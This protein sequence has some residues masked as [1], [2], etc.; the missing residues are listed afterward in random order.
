MASLSRASKEVCI[1]VMSSCLDTISC[2]PSFT[3]PTNSIEVSS[4]VTRLLKAPIMVSIW[5]SRDFKLMVM[6]AKT[7]A[8][9]TIKPPAT[10]NM[11]MCCLR[12]SFIKSS[13]LCVAFFM[14]SPAPTAKLAERVASSAD[15]S[16]NILT[17]S[18]SSLSL[19]GAAAAACAA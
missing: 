15:S 9:T 4:S 19:T 10:A 13:R 17:P 7:A 16:A 18:S 2:K 12:L 14:F 1:L 11:M 3:E 5:L 6:A 8:T